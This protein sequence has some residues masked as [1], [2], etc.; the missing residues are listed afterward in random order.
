[1]PRQPSYVAQLAAILR[2]GNPRVLRQFLMDNAAR[3]GDQRQVDDIESKSDAEMEELLHRMIL[4]RP[5]LQD[6]HRGSREWLFRQG[7][8]SYGESG[9]RR[10]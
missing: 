4:A 3:F 1:M 2:R 7:L 6:L 8:D 5:D 9:G 10:N